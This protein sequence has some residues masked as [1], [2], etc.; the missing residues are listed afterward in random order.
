ML[1]WLLTWHEKV[2]GWQHQPF[3]DGAWLRWKWQWK[4][5]APL[6]G[7]WPRGLC[8]LRIHN[9]FIVQTQPNERTY[10][11]Y[12]WIVALE[13]HIYFSTMNL[14]KYKH[15]DHPVL[16]CWPSCW[17]I[18]FSCSGNEGA[19]CKS[20]SHRIAMRMVPP[21]FTWQ[22]CPWVASKKLGPVPEDGGFQWFKMI[23][24]HVS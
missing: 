8:N 9:I 3:L 11:E 4:H 13:I 17:Y 10:C 24:K 21:R 6:P 14:R 19:N 7:G 23:Q 15:P 12:L 20:T 2:L 22:L 16:T 1:C 5:Q 18:F